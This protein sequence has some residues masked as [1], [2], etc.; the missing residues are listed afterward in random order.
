MRDYGRSIAEEVPVGSKGSN[1]I[2]ERVVQE[3]E[4]LF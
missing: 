3:V 4:G 2:V 1:G